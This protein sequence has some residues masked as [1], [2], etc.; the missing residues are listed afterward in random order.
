MNILVNW[1]NSTNDAVFYVQ[2]ESKKN[3]TPL[4]MSITSWKIDRFSRFFHW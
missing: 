2:C 1:Y 4:L 3:K